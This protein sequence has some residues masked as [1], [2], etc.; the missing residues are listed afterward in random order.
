MDIHVCDLCGESSAASRFTRVAQLTAED[1][2]NDAG[3]RYH[4][5]TRDVCKSC[6][7]K[8]IKQLE[9]TKFTPDNPS[10]LQRMFKR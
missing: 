5:W 2:G 1:Y 10:L 4:K 3:Y 8:L 6:L 7:G 9:A